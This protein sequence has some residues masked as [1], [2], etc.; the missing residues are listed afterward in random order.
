MAGQAGALVPRAG[1]D[2]GAQAG[3]AGQ[4]EGGQAGEAAGAAAIFDDGCA[5]LDR[6]GASDCSET[7]L[8]NSNFATDV[9]D[10]E[11]EVGATLAWDALDLSGAEDSGSALV[12]STDALDALGSSLV[13]ASQ[14]IAVE[15][16]KELEIFGQVQTEVSD[17]DGNAAIS[18][19]FFPTQACGQSPSSVFQTEPIP[20]GKTVILRGSATVP[21]SMTTARVRLAVIKP[22]KA[23]SFGV[24]F[25]NLLVI[26][27]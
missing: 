25:D 23:P 1:S 27:R 13:S 15:A 16:G 3:Q 26:A 17:T 5:D 18:V 14:C 12:T 9:S 22:F 20:T 10:W 6:N 8:D 2:A 19:W 21:E 11:V 7:L 4:A 24:H